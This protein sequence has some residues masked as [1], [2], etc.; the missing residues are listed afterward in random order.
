MAKF[1]AGVEEEVVEWAAFMPLPE[2]HAEARLA[3][4]REA[5]AVGDE[6]RRAGDEREAQPVRTLAR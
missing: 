6:A 1:G 3:A 5:S 4:A 2:Q